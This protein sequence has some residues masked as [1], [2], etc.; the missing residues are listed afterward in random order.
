MLVG[1]LFAQP[2]LRLPW[3]SRIRRPAGPSVIWLVGPFPP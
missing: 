2:V 3:L 1:P